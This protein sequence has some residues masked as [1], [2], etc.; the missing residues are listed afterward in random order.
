MTP[1][2]FATTY[3]GPDSDTL[4]QPQC[5]EVVSETLS[6]QPVLKRGEDH[7]DLRLFLF[8]SLEL[9]LASAMDLLRENLYRIRQLKS[10]Q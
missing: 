2:A 10:T 9:W 5:R 8:E 6:Q 1:V 3:I 4:R 7:T